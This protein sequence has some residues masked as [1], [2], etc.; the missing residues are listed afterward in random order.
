M[1]YKIVYAVIENSLGVINCHNINSI[2]N[3]KS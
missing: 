1:S 2:L 3:D